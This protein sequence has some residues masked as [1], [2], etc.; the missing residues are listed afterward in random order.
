VIADGAGP[1]RGALDVP[2]D[3]RADLLVRLG[4]AQQQADDPGA[5]DR[6]GGAGPRL[7]C[8]RD[9]GLP[10]MLAMIGGLRRD[11]AMMRR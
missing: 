8:D 4:H 9:R 7:R 2:V 10:G 1:W 3:E 11:A 6:S 5:L